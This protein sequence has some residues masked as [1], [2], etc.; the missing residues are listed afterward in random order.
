MQLNLHF[1]KKN[2]YWQHQ[3]NSKQSSAFSFWTS[4]KNNNPNTADAARKASAWL[5]W[6]VAVWRR[7]P[8]TRRFF[9]GVWTGELRLSPLFGSTDVAQFYFPPCQNKRAHARAQQNKRRQ[10]QTMTQTH[11][12]KQPQICTYMGLPLPRASRI[13]LSASKDTHPSLSPR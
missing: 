8:A 2:C 6:H 11:K 12:K 5:L 10:T 4:A 13:Q 7:Q 9:H 1:K 3:L